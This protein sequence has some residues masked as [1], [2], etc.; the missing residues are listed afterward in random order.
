MAL[1]R[2]LF[3]GKKDSFLWY[4]AIFRCF[5]AM[6]R[7]EH[8]GSEY[9]VRQ[10]GAAGLNTLR[11]WPQ[12]IREAALRAAHSHKF[13]NPHGCPP[14]LYLRAPSIVNGPP[15][16]AG[17]AMFLEKTQRGKHSYPS[18]TGTS[19]PHCGHLGSAMCTMGAAPR[20]RG[21]ASR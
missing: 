4:V 1:R 11:T 3:I 15:D 10:P 7:R 5:L 17:R 21:R 8:D 14:R 2:C 12:Y 13:D 6:R 16:A 9:A 19:T 20:N 18:T